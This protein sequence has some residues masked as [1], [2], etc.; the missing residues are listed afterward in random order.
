[1]KK[2]LLLFVLPILVGCNQATTSPSDPGPSE[3]FNC[4]ILPHL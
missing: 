4:D 3:P 1:M 2:L